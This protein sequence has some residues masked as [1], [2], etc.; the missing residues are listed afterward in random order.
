MDV[1]KHFQHELFSDILVYSKCRN[2]LNQ[3]YIFSWVSI[4][5]ELIR[6]S[7]YNH[8]AILP[9]NSFFN[10]F[11]TT[12]RHVFDLPIDH[13]VAVEILSKFYI[14][15]KREQQFC[16]KLP[17]HVYRSSLVCNR[18]FKGKSFNYQREQTMNIHYHGSREGV[19]RGVVCAL[20]LF[21]AIF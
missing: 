14:L 9:H 3:I 4:L 19:G 5:Y 20:C 12:K 16:N 15:A 13:H 2:V 17:H 6:Y 1:T 11:L 18:T 7:K 21:V 10:S 8:T